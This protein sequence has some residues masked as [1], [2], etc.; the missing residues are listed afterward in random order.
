MKLL[1]IMWSSFIPLLKDAA[2]ATGVFDLKAYSNKQLCMD[3]A[4]IRDAGKEMETADLI[5]LYRTAEPFWDEIEERI[6]E[7]GGRIPVIA[8]GPQPFFRKISNLSPEIVTTVYRYLL[9]NGAENFREMLKFLASTLFSVTLPFRPPKETAWEGIY[10]PECGGP[11]TCTRDYLDLYGLH[12]RPLVA[13]LYSRSNWVAGNMDVERRIIGALEQEGL[14]VLPVFFYPFKDSNLG[15]LGGEDIIRKFLLKDSGESLVD[16]VVKLTVFF[17]GQKRGESSESQAE[18]GVSLLKE[19]NVPL[20][21]P[22]ISY[23]KDREKWLEDPEGLGQQVA[24][25]IALPEFEGVIEPMVVGAGKG[26]S[27][28]EEDLRSDSG[29]D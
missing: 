1:T 9:F 29:Q 26:A 22:V 8:V 27:N 21:N 3:L 19:L 18:S 10:H 5:L 23:Y 2:R 11:F 28:P 7:L 6:G 13:L 12:D 20:I 15:N 14:G 17:L 24:W 16:A 25:S 4:M